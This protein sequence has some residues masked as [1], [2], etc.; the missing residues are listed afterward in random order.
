MIDKMH[1]KMPSNRPPD[2]QTFEWLPQDPLHAKANFNNEQ[3][4]MTNYA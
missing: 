1:I 3:A 4:K 2:N